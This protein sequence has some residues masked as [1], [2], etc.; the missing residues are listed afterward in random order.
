MWDINKVFPT[1]RVQAVFSY[2]KIAQQELLQFSSK[3]DG[4]I[5]CEIRFIQD[6]LVHHVLSLAHQHGISPI[7]EVACSSQVALKGPKII[8]PDWL[9]CEAC[10]H[11]SMD[12][13][14]DDYKQVINPLIVEF[15]ENYA[16]KR[17]AACAQAN[18]ETLL[19]DVYPEQ[20]QPDFAI[21]YWVEDVK[22]LLVSLYLTS[23]Q[24]WTKAFFKGF[25]CETLEEAYAQT[26]EYLFKGSM[27]TNEEEKKYCN[28]SM[29]AAMNVVLM[30]EEMG[31]KKIAPL[32]KSYYDRC[33]RHLQ[34]ARKKKNQDAIIKAEIELKMCPIIYGYND[35]DVKLYREA[36][37]GITKS[38]HWRREHWHHYWVG[39]ERSQLVKKKLLPI[40]VNKHLLKTT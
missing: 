8:R 9:N 37:S 22:I 15:P 16:K 17:I 29:R 35:P 26:Q 23:G 36:Q 13:K 4:K 24:V 6:E 11:M 34:V 32:N 7:I 1:N 28:L 38:P 5:D 12:V 21:L 20:H 40:L 31:I 27:E 2:R 30:T 33:E 18:E 25:G 3:E 19:N 14:I 39:K 10:E